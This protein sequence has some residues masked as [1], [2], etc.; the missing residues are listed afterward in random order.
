[1]RTAWAT[2]G[3]FKKKTN[4]CRTTPEQP[5]PGQRLNER[6]PPHPGSSV[7][8]APVLKTHTLVT[9]LCTLY[10]LYGVQIMGYANQGIESTAF[11][12][13]SVYTVCCTVCRE[14]ALLLIPRAPWTNPQHPGRGTVDGKPVPPQNRWMDGWREDGA[15]FQAM[16]V[17]A[18]PQLPPTNKSCL[19]GGEAACRLLSS[20]VLRT[21]H[22]IKDSGPPPPVPSLFPRLWLCDDARTHEPSICQPSPFGSSHISN[23][24]QKN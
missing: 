4:E 22:Y 24:K 13:S 2:T 20:Q 11:A 18:P 17:A 3:N 10:N 5:P 15:Q 8:V 14:E 7:E 23:K 16:L 12:A 19:S 9:P 21:S 6:S 1:M